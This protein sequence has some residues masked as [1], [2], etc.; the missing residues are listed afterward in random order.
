VIIINKYELMLIVDPAVEADRQAEILDRLRS[1]VEGS[2]GTIVGT[3]TS[4]PWGKRKLAYEINGLT[5]GTY[6]VVTFTA[7]PQTVAEV[8]RVLSITDDVVRFITLRL[9]A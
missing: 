3:D 1:T 6:S 8:E 5:E 2:K 9:K 4:A 7:T